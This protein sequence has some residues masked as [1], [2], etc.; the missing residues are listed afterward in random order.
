M[1]GGSRSLFCG[2]ICICICICICRRCDGPRAVTVT[3]AITIAIAIAIAIAITA[4][5]TT[6]ITIAITIAAGAV[7]YQHSSAASLVHDCLHQS[8]S[9]I[10]PQNFLRILC[11]PT[12]RT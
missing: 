1:K 6:A 12:R 10:A 5:I 9:A 3:V 8:W 7:L 2:A 4:A 11:R